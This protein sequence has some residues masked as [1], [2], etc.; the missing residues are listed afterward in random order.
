[1]ISV[2]CQDLPQG[3]HLAFVKTWDAWAA[4]GG[5]RVLP[6]RWRDFNELAGH[7]YRWEDVAETLNLSEMLTP[8]SEEADKAGESAG[9]TPVRIFISYAR[10]DDEYRAKLEENLSSLKHHKLVELW[11]D[12]CIVPGDDWDDAIDEN[13]RTA[14]VVLLL[15][16]QAF[17][18]SEYITSKE[19]ELALARH[20]DK[21]ARVVPVILRP[22]VWD[23]TPFARFQAIPR[24]RWRSQS[25]KTSTKRGST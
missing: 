12:R 16:S 4:T 9:T 11:T 19:L 13:I 18:N 15:V 3:P 21:K 25:G 20:E 17:V 5:V 8:S 7:D 1:V 22:A 6:V 23:E 10:E 14:D 2:I 24:T